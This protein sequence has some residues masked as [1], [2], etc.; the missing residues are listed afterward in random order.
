MNIGFV[1]QSNNSLEFDY[2]YLISF[3][4]VVRI[5][6]W[7]LVPSAFAMTLWSKKGNPASI[8]LS[9]LRNVWFRIDFRAQFF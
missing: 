3:F 1:L 2:Q 5:V 9:W 7:V 4:C 8:S 6:Q